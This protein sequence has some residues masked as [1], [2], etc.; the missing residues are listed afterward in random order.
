MMYSQDCERMQPLV[1][2]SDSDY[3]DDYAT[4]YKTREEAERA[5]LKHP[6]ASVLGFEVFSMDDCV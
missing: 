3:E 4:G 5:G 6:Y 2:N 1:G